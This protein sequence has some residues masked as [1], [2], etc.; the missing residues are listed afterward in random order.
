M[1]YIHETVRDSDN[2]IKYYVEDTSKQFNDKTVCF[3]HIPRTGGRWVHYLLCQNGFHVI[4]KS[5][6]KKRGA[7]Y[8]TSKVSILRKKIQ[9]PEKQFST[10]RHP[11]DRIMSGY[12]AIKSA[13]DKFDDYDFM[14]DFLTSST[15]EQVKAF[16]CF[17]YEFVDNQVH[18]YRFE[19]GLDEKY[20]QWFVNTLGFDMVMKMPKALPP[21]TLTDERSMSKYA[22]LLPEKTVKNLYRYYEQDFELFGYT[23]D[24][25]L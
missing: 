8:H 12:D 18:T 14:V 9:L 10:I 13:F 21:K 3:F 7:D 22:K 11:I 6:F 24:G 2:N 19:D 5:Y 25:Y 1:I 23:L 16:T 4:N 20:L 15:E 17:Q